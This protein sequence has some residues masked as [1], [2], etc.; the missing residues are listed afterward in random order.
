MA[1]IKAIIFA[2]AVA[3]GAF[4]I[5]H[6]ADLGLP[7]PPP[8]EAPPPPV[9]SGWYL[10][11]D[12]GVGFDQLSNFY[13][14]D[15]TLPIGFAYNGAGLGQQVNIGGGVGYQVNNWIRFD[16]TGEY[17]TQTK[18]WGVESYTVACTG[19]GPTCYDD[20]SGHVS[21]FDVLANG[22]IDLGTWYNFTPFIG[23]GIGAA[24]NQ[25]SGLT[26]VGV[27]TGGFGVAPSSNSV[28]LA[29]AVHAGVD[30]SFTPNWKLEVA[31][32]YFN[33][34]KVTSDGIVCTA[35]CTHEVQSFNIASQDVMVGLRYVFAE[36]PA[37][38]PPLVTKY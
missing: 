5:A 38:A 4:N 19:G 13:S 23:A 9:V 8:V 26:D 30:Y 3:I 20:Y 37:V 7:P 18:Y 14:T 1:S 33:G 34:G 10:R 36:V 22:Y 21:T 27:S 11:G 24:F 25:F 29:W 32:R 31:Y 12:V 16:V 35:G 28:D 2:S 6:A 15:S 17:R